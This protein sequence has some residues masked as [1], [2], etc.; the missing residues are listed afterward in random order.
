MSDTLKLHESARFFAGSARTLMARLAR[1]A[2]FAA[3]FAAILI[4]VLALDRSMQQLTRAETQARTVAEQHR[5]LAGELAQ[6]EARNLRDH[7]AEGFRF[8]RI[9]SGLPTLQS[10]RREQCVE[11]LERQLAN[12]HGFDNVGISDAQGRPVCSAKPVPADL[13][14]DNTR[15]DEISLAAG[16]L[17]GV[18]APREALVVAT[19]MFDGER[20]IGSA[21]LFFDPHA[22]TATLD[23]RNAISVSFLQGEQ[24][25]SRPLRAASS[26]PVALGFARLNDAQ[27]AL[28]FSLGI[29]MPAQ[30]AL[31]YR[32]VYTYAGMLVLLLALA[33]YLGGFGRDRFFY[34]IVADSV[35]GIG[36]Q[37]AKLGSRAFSLTRRSRLEA[38]R[39]QT[40][41]ELREANEA[42]KRELEQFQ[43]R[44]REMAELNEMSRHLQTCASATEIHSTVEDYAQRLF[45]AL[46]GAL[47]THGEAHTEF[48]RQRCW[49]ASCDHAKVIEVDD[50]WALRMG[51]AHGVAVDTP[52]LRCAHLDAQSHASY[53]CAPLIAHG[54]MSGLLHLQAH[55]PSESNWPST[56]IELAQEF[57]ERIALALANFNMRESLR[58]QSIRD[59][60][61]GLYNRRFLDETL[62]LEEQR[63]RRDGASVGIVMLDIDHFKQFNDTFGHDAGDALLREL[64]SFLRTQVR[65]G[66]T[67]C[68]YGGEEFTLILPSADFESSRL[69]A[70]MLRRKVA[71]VEIEY[72]GQKL[73]PITLSLGVATY[74]QHGRSWREV[75]KAADRALYRAKKSGRNRVALA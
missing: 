68:R 7:F 21:F 40:K 12:V 65:E 57:A 75:L 58:V 63:A 72:H 11:V 6:R 14:L 26:G 41:I 48:E 16:A 9:I 59:A 22:L 36:A 51:T 60:L 69:R 56:R 17:P 18:G 39:N 53:L 24:V 23:L 3:V 35:S 67:A 19:P 47:Y 62:A 45:G 38:R 27:P 49:G 31:P 54:E 33:T 34:H 15:R 32:P 2:A 42:L 25:S 5:L 46:A 29:A 43:L 8:L 37:L 50:C 52:S 61:T 30:P 28:Y 66:D 1:L 73:G 55:E 74:P 20:F 4:T 64:G 71:G 44:D 10:A 70:E 13:R